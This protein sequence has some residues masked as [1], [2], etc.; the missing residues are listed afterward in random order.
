MQI[1]AGLLAVSL[2][3]LSTARTEGA[4]CLPLIRMPVLS[5]LLL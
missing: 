1:D 5:A 3:G 4:L 2:R